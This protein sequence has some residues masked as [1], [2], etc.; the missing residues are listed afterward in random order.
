MINQ[1]TVFN[2]LTASEWRQVKTSFKYI[3][4]VIQ[5]IVKDDLKW[6]RYNCQPRVTVLDLYVKTWKLPTTEY[7]S[8]KTEPKTCQTSS[9]ILT[10][11]QS[12]VRTDFYVITNTVDSMMFYMIIDKAFIQV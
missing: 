12:L 4:L 1:E 2:A 10:P 8:R 7:G 6:T 3:C 9:C 11:K 5:E